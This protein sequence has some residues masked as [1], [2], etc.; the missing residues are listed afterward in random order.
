[1]TTLIT[2]SL[3]S[4][5][6]RE[7]LERALICVALNNGNTQKSA[8]QLAKEGIHVSKDSLWAWTRKNPETMRLY[9]ELQEECLPEIRQKAAERHMEAAESTM[10]LAA[11]ARQRLKQELPKIAARDLPGALRNIDTSTAI[12][13]DKARDLRGEASLVT[14]TDKRDLQTVLRSLKGKGLA[15]AEEVIDA[16]V[17]EDAPKPELEAA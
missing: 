10:D 15:K 7:E 4:K 9:F 8:E 17:V 14:A 5:F 11:E 6:S 2:K 12:H 13:R 3:S 1:M 16:E